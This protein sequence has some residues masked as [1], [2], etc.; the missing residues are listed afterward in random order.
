MT[1]THVLLDCQSLCMISE[2]RGGSHQAGGSR[3]GAWKTGAEQRQRLSKGAL[4]QQ[5]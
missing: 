1:I 5:K 3:T 4:L 2:T